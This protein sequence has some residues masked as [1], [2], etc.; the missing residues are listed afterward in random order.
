MQT[1][2]YFNFQAI[3]FLYNQLIN[4]ENIKNVKFP[5]A[6]AYVKLWVVKGKTQVFIHQIK[7]AIHID[8]VMFE[9]DSLDVI[10]NVIMKQFS[11]YFC[12]KAETWTIYLSATLLRRLYFYRQ[13]APDG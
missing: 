3:K 4:S 9:N 11:Q 2:S 6:Y 1:K 8:Q 7:H 5:D 10:W 13:R 12:E